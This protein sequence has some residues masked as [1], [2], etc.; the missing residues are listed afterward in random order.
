SQVTI[1]GTASDT[2]GVVGGVEVS[3]DGGTTWHPA[4]G[5]GSWTFLWTVNGSGQVTIKSRAVDDSGNL[6]TPGAGVTVTVSGAGGA[7]P[8][9]IWPASPTPAVASAP[10]NA[11]VNVGVKF[12][13]DQNGFITGIR[14]YKGAANIG[15]HVGRLWTAGGT[16]LA[17]ATFTNETASG[18]Q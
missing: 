18:W 1:T 13:S 8:C 4:T 16:Q 2:G 10:D 9:T 11:S 17:S 12:R 7:C 15:T 14:F 3:V 5:R 6:E